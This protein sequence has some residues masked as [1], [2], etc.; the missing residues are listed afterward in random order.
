MAENKKHHYV[1]RFYLKRFSSNGKSINLYNIKSS[2]TI[3]EGNLKNQC[4][5][6]YFYGENQVL[7]HA[8]ADAE[9]QAAKLLT[10]ID[11]YGSLPP[12]L[13]ATH[14]VLV[15]HVLMQYA[16]T[17]Y[18]AEAIDEM[19]DQVMKHLV[20][21]KAEAEGI[22][23][24][25][26]TIGIKDSASYSLRMSVQFYPLLFDLKYK[27]LVNRTNEE[28]ITS[29][30]PV[31]FYNQFFYFRQFGSNTGLAC[32]GLQIFF[33]IDHQKLVLLYD[34]SIYGVGANQDGVVEI[35]N[36]KDIYALNM[37]QMCSAREN[38][39]AKSPTF[40]FHAL[41]KKSIP[42]LRTRKAN[43]EIFPQGKSKYEKREI[44]ATSREDVRTNLNL[45]FVR[46]RQSAK[47]WRYTFRKNR[48]QPSAVVRDEQMCRDHE[49]FLKLVDS[50]KYQ[51]GD[52]F[53]FLGEKYG[54]KNT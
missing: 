13:S 39:Y 16:R 12:F 52:F 2:K 42:Y 24:T 11:Q 50:E 43:L 35:T 9:G 45:S 29:D 14:G 17:A 49:E 15:L 33:P 22:D 51:P 47:T 7:E 21:P 37:L 23:L 25:K 54:G 3:L 36:K 38:I 26:V 48:L 40:N 1:P 5:Q 44:L 41:H 27:L 46:V 32:K 8:L 31:V 6:N 53:I 30:N 34:D 19:Y 28:F 10:L 20:G 18:S 4:Y